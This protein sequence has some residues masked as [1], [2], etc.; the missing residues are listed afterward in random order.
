MSNT[1]HLVESSELREAWAEFIGRFMWEWFCTFTFEEELHPEQADKRYRKYV[2]NLNLTIFGKRYLR[3]KVSG[4]PWVR[5]TEWQQRGVIHFHALM[6]GGVS[7]LRRLTWMDYWDKRFPSD[8]EGS[9][10]L[11]I[12][13]NGFCRIRP[14]NPHLGARFYLAKCLAKGGEIDLFIPRSISLV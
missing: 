3:H 11:Y 7:K 8:G 4:I 2:R 9:T 12:G 10:Q 14:Y 13:G 1:I 5:S 6:G